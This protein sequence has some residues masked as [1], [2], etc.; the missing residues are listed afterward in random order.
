MV[1]NLKDV[2]FVT[3]ALLETRKSKSHSSN[4]L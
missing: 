4:A 1:F 3:S 2:K